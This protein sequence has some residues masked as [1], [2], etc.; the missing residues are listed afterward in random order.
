M[1]RYVL[2]VETIDESKLG[3]L[4]L[5]HL[6]SHCWLSTW[7]PSVGWNQLYPLWATLEPCD[8]T[9]PVVTDL[10]P[11]TSYGQVDENNTRLVIAVSRPL[12]VVPVWVCL[13]TH[14]YNIP[15]HQIISKGVV[16]FKT[17]WA[18]FSKAWRE[19][20]LLHAGN[21]CLT[22]FSCPDMYTLSR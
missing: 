18:L 12:P 17:G 13:L 22:T 20:T 16:W 1:C 19:S 14:I 4:Y 8:V 2:S 10:Y 9:R 21:Y 11:C 6:C 15:W 3:F 7:F 5:T